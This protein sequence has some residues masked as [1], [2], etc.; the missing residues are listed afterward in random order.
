MPEYTRKHAKSG[1]KDK[2]PKIEVWENQFKRNYT[3]TLIYP[4]FNSVC[5]KTGLPDLGTI[6]I[7]YIPEKYVVEMKSLK[8]YLVAY[9]NIGI[10][11]ENAVNR[12]LNDFVKS[13]KPKWCRITGKFLP[14][15]GMKNI[16]KVEYRKNEK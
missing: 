12:I 15:G 14:R 6:T 4:E 13:V 11:Q 10:F 8:L 3:I 9:R 2:L 1:L 7:E 5:P 16:I